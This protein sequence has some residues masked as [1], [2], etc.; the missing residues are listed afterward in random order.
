MTAKSTA[1]TTTNA[2]SIALREDGL[3]E[4]EIAVWGYSECSVME[5]KYD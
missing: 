2:L 4:S 5:M 3:Q 1:T